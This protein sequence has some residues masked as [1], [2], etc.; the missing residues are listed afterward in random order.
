MTEENAPKGL[1]KQLDEL[2]DKAIANASTV[3]FPPGVETIGVMAEWGNQGRPRWFKYP[4][5]PETQKPYQL[6]KTN[7]AVTPS[8]TWVFNSYRG[9]WVPDLDAQLWEYRMKGDWYQEIDEVEARHLF[10]KA[11]ETPDRVGKTWEIVVTDE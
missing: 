11:F 3:E 7:A 6:F 4:E 5:W 2:N 1:G 9:R 8:S 10:K